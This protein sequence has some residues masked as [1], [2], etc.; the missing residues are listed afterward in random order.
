MALSPFNLQA[1]LQRSCLGKD[2]RTLMMTL[3]SCRATLTLLRTR[4]EI[5]LPAPPHC[6]V[7]CFLV[8]PS[9][10]LVLLGLLTRLRGS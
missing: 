10:L 4:C 8:Q 9:C 1:L 2:S 7:A 6:V 3:F 5:A